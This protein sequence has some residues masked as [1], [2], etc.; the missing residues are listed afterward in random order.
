[1]SCKFVVI[2][3]FIIIFFTFSFDHAI[4]Q[5]EDFVIHLKTPITKYYVNEHVNVTGNVFN[6]TNGEGISTSV[7]LRVLLHNTL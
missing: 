4:A 6:S 7:M 5:T 3:L 2:A 1:M